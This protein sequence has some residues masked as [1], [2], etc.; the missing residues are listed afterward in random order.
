MA[1]SLN[2]L[3]ALNSSHANMRPMLAS[4]LRGPSYAAATRL[5]AVAA[6][7][8]ICSTRFFS[9]LTPAP[10]PTT[11]S[12]PSAMR[13]PT[14]VDNVYQQPTNEIQGLVKEGPTRISAASPEHTS[15]S[16][17]HER[18]HE[19]MLT[20]PE[21]LEEVKLEKLRA[22]LMALPDFPTGA[23]TGYG[24]FV[25]HCYQTSAITR[26][27]EPKPTKAI[28]MWKA[29]SDTERQKFN[30]EA[31]INQLRVAEYDEWAQ[32][33]GYK[34]LRQINRD[35][36][37]SGKKTLRMPTS[38]RPVRRSSGFRTF[39]EEKVASGEIS[40]WEGFSAAKKHA[41]E[42]WSELDSSQQAIYETQSKADHQQRLAA[43]LRA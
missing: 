4:A 12:N 20:S 38:L 17:D 27:F 2:L 39:F 22:E 43:R 6:N 40:T 26:E 16:P 8:M 31:D 37:L 1:I 7:P 14:G 24:C 9:D 34:S 21:N 19:S 35:R 15:A 32:A 13:A 25:R 29:L 42:L 30:A 23:T 10:S 3:R 41:S 33:V 28:E 18:G 5:S 36:V 11:N